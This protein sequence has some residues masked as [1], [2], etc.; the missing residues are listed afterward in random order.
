VF[1]LTFYKLHLDCVEPCDNRDRVAGEGRCVAPTPLTTS[2][3]MPPVFLKVKGQGFMRP[4]V[5]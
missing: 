2:Y 1:L 5:L 3:G 4:N